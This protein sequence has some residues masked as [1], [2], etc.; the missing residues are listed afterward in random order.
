MISTT[1]LE[2]GIDIGNIFAVVQLTPPNTVSSFM[3]KLGRSGRSKNT[4]SRTIVFY[5]NPQTIFMTLAEIILAKNNQV[6]DVKII[7]KPYDIYFHQIL[8]TLYNKGKMEDT[9]LYNFL[10]NCYVFENISLSEYNQLINYM[11][12][13]EFLNKHSNYLST[14]YNFEKKYGKINYRDFYAVFCPTNEFDVKE[15]I[16][17]IG[18]I[19]PIYAL[20]LKSGDNFILA[21]QHWKIN[22]IDTLKYLI[23]V[24][25]AK[26]KK[27]EVP[28]WN[29]DGPQLSYTLTRKIY[30][31]LLNK[32]DKKILNYDKSR[33]DEKSKEIISLHINDCA[34]N[35]FNQNTIPIE[36]DSK[37]GE[38]FIYTFAGDKANQ[39]LS[40][41]FKLYF[42]TYNNKNTPFYCSFKIR[43]DYKYEDIANVIFNVKTLLSKKENKIKIINL[44]DTYYKNKFINH[45]P[46]K[47]NAQL[48]FELLFDEKDLI[49]LCEKNQ[50]FPCGKSL[51]REW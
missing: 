10:K 31:L 48:K 2:L 49:N 24:T 40:L 35:G 42:E 15:G 16:K 23:Q 9:K 13:E 6:E 33:F 50:P 18:T 30:S 44:M 7:K 14:G 22:K 43:G 5:Q 8:S 36:L 4:P 20:M 19:D 29:G 3:Q 47:F 1:T 17:T 34:N 12:E 41:I 46:P 25:K 37:S 32:F 21:G 28:D 39:L 51:I 27:G 11:I 38:I 26:S 45:I